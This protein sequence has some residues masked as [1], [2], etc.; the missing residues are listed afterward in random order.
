MIAIVLVYVGFSVLIKRWHELNESA[1]WV[2]LA[3]VPL[4]NNNVHDFFGISKATPGA[5]ELGAATNPTS[6][7]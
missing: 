4:A 2:R 3:F 5:N 6:F 7:V 1:W